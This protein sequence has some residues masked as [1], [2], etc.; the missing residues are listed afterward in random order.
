MKFIMIGNKL[1][2]AELIAWVEKDD[3]ET[4]TLHF[5]VPQGTTVPYVVSPAGRVPAAESDH[6]TMHFSGE[7]ASDL[8]TRLQLG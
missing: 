4:V 8:W 1:I 6:F 5:P 7:E 2:N 3:A